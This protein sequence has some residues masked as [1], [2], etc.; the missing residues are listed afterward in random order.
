MC[1]RDRHP[2]YEV[3]TVWRRKDKRSR[4]RFHERWVRVP[5]GDVDSLARL[6]ENF[7]VL[8]EA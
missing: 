8:R 3:V 5:G 2:D 7:N 4:W 6:D 1:I